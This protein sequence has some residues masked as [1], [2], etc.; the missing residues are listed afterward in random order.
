[1]LVICLLS[2]III[3][4]ACNRRQEYT[5]YEET[6]IPVVTGE[7]GDSEESETTI[8]NEFPYSNIS[9]GDLLSLYNEYKSIYVEPNISAINTPYY[10]II[11]AKNGGAAYSKANAE[12]VPLC[13][14]P[15]CNH[16]NCIY[17]DYVTIVDYEV[18]DDR[19]YLLVNSFYRYEL[20]SFDFWMNDIKKVA[21]WEI[22]DLPTCLHYYE[23][24]IYYQ[25]FYLHEKEPILTTFML[26]TDNGDKTLLWGTER[27]DA[28]VGGYENRLYYKSHGSIYSYDLLTK[29]DNCIV[30]ASTLDV[31]KGEI[32]LN[33][34]WAN[35]KV[36]SYSTYSTIYGT[37]NYEFNFE[38]GEC[39]ICIKQNDSQNSNVI[40]FGD[41]Y[42]FFV[43][44]DTPD[45]KEHEH[46]NY[47]I[48]Q[49]EEFF[50]KANMSGGEIWR[51]P[52]SGGKA[53][54]VASMT[55]DG[56]PDNIQYLYTYDGKYLVVRYESYMDY[57]NEYNSSF[58]P[59]AHDYVQCFRFALI[60]VE[61]GNVFTF[62]TKGIY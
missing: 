47:F 8:N 37:Q 9:S 45:Y 35:D 13:K 42:Y 23:G 52:I 33:F 56:I 54:L 17:K 28:I 25:A 62:E 34:R 27:F 60:D 44:H 22:E 3:L 59:F 5:H 19:I 49:S 14:D 21:D 15:L 26:N 61:S 24:Q 29:K 12:I 16:K 55:T 48:K 20:Y 50:G 40:R 30:P 2:L 4:P 43:R 46:Y 38:T 41:Y 57:Q 32:S 51:C 31:Q 36:I 58:N 10:I 7:G 6:T 39:N 18:S 1:M 53:E 11:S